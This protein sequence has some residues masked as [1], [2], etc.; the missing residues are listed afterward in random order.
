MNQL[1]Q[2]KL[3]YNPWLWEPEAKRL[4][5]ENEY[6]KS[7]LVERENRLEEI[8]HSLANND[9]EVMA[10]RAELRESDL[11]SAQLSADCSYLVDRVEQLLT[12]NNRLRRERGAM[13]QRIAKILEG[14]SNRPIRILAGVG[15]A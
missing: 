3:K 14:S 9:G 13:R 7:Q 11:R 10:L 5:A 4:G 12:E 2:Q 6:L 8:E 15:A 1:L